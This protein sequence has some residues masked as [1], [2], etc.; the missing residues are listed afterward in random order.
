[1]RTELLDLFLCSRCEFCISTS[2]GLDGVIDVFRKPLLI[3]NFV[4]FSKL[5][6]ERANVLTMFKHHFS[7]TLNKKITMF[8]IKK[9][10]L[11]SAFNK[12]DFDFNK[13][14]LIENSEKEIF[15]AVIDLIHFIKFKTF[16]ESESLI[17]V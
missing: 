13:I 9:L 6:H 11:E 16:N 7:K 17:H 14:R 15:D 4:P 8:E 2:L 10:N 12:D 5:R 3:T 1:M